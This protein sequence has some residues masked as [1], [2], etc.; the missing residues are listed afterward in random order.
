M[1]LFPPSGHFR[2]PFFSE[3][4]L[5]IRRDWMRPLTNCRILH[6]LPSWRIDS[7]AQRVILFSLEKAAIEKFLLQFNTQILQNAFFCGEH[8]SYQRKYIVGSDV[9]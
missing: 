3:I 6:M 4:E 2:L 5:D 1:D 9:L 7:T 8:P